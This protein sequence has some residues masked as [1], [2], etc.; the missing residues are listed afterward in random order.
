V[1]RARGGYGIFHWIFDLIGVLVTGGLWL[2]W[3]CVRE[4]GRRSA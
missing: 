2:I 4:M 3:I 1:S